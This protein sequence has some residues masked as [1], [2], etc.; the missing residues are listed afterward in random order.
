MA[1][2]AGCCGVYF[3]LTSA[4]HLELPFDASAYGPDSAE[5]SNALGPLLGA[6][7]STGNSVT[8]LVN[9]DQFF[10]AMLQAVR[11]AKKTITFESY[12][13]AP[14]KISDAFIEALSER[15]RHGVKVHVMIDGMGTLKFRHQDRQRMEAA[16]IELLKYGREHW[17]QIKP[18]IL[19]RTH[20]KLLIVDG[21]VGFT[22]GMCIDDRWMGDAESAK[23][24]R[25]TQVRVEGP[26]VLQMQAVFA[27]NWLQTSSRLL[28]GPDYFPASLASGPSLAQSIKSGPGEGQA[29]IRLSYLAAIAAAHKTIEIANAYFVPDD[30]AIATL[31]EARKR[32]VRVRII[33]PAI[34]DSRIGRAVS[35]SRWGKLLAAGVEIHE[36]LPAMFHAKTMVVDNVF[37]TIGSANFDNRSFSIN[38]E[39]ALNVI[40]PDFG[41]AQ[42]AVFENDLKHCRRVYQEKFNNRP[43]FI[44]IFDEL[45]GLLRS[46]F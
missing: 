17:Y 31:L 45:C 16:G 25:E 35:R 7:F 43:V 44:R 39:N 15:A 14:G 24:W 28:I 33:V 21:R 26:V 42:L 9:G 11:E 22:G 34:N 27:T 30:L 10:P 2:A 18:D 38:D 1:A 6:D 20:R 40:D 19:H 41:R 3:W 23:V 32:G 36:Y 29:T 46:Q 4:P 12:I 8:A 37:V 5:F 13:W